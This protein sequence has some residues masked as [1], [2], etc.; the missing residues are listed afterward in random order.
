MT[1]IIIPKSELIIPTGSLQLILRNAAT[2]RIKS[3]DTVPNMVVTAGKSAIADAL[4]GTTEN[5]KGI[6]TYCAVG[7]GSTAP[8]EADTTLETELFRKLISVRSVTANAALFETFYTT[9]EA[10]GTLAE[11]GLFGD[12]AS[13]SADSGTLFARVLISRTKSANDTLTLRWT[14]TIG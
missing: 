6:I 11:A 1:N 7:T 2:G 12:D 9:S 10:N 8:V 5:N 14:L 4:Q 13:A 3:V